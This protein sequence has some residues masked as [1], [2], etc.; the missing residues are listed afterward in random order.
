MYARCA[1]VCPRFVDIR[2]IH[3]RA[4][5]HMYAYMHAHARTSRIKT[6]HIRSDLA[7]AQAFGEAKDAI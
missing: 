2:M 1:C 5:M 4:H 3:V 6:C 7:R